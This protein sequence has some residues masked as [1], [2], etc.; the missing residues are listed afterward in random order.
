MPATDD[1]RE[2][3]DVVNHVL[4]GGLSSRLFEEIREQRGLVYSVYSGVSAYADA[5]AY[6]I[7]AGHAARATPTR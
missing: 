3:L 5:G 1:D 4:G 6:S 7:Y 2:A